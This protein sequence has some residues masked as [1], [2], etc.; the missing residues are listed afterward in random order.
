MGRTGGGRDGGIGTAGR[1]GRWVTGRFV[2]AGLPA[3]GIG[4][5]EAGLERPCLGVG[6]QRW[7]LA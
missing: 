4:N 7:S 5:D 2:L 1:C 6:E 3:E